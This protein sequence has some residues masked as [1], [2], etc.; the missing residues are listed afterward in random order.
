LTSK[1]AFELHVPLP[2][3]QILARVLGGFFHFVQFIVQYVKLNR[4]H[5]EELAWEEML[6]E[7]RLPDAIDSATE[8]WY[9][10]ALVEGLLIGVAFLN[11]FY[12]FSRTK[13]YHLYLRPDLVSSPHAQFVAKEPEQDLSLVPSS[14]A[15]RVA[16]F[17]FNFLNISWRFLLGIDS[18]ASILHK[19]G[20][21][22]QLDIWI[23]GEVE[24]ALF[25]IYSPAHALIWRL[26]TSSNWI[27]VLA[28]M[29]LLSGQFYTLTRSYELLIKDRAIISSEVMHEYDEKF[30][31]P[32]I[33]VVK[34]DACVMT[35]EAEVVSYR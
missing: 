8:S 27:L 31:I 35:H 16:A 25:S 32:R 23:P 2:P 5:E 11:A 33:N 19:N 15:S 7:V 28:L 24:L 22:Q 21:V 6:N 34:S 13:N 14:L 20:K 29:L 12:L 26:V 10:T 1:F 9:W 4:L 17:L 30:V 3:P 18:P